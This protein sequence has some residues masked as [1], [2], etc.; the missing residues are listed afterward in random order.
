MRLAWKFFNREVD[1]VVGYVTTFIIQLVGNVVVPL[2]VCVI[3]FAFPALF[4]RCGIAASYAF[5]VQVERRGLLSE[6]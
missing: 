3:T 2:A 6:F 4:V 1:T 5:V